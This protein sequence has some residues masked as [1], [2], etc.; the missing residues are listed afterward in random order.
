MIRRV[1]GQQDLPGDGQLRLPPDG[2]IVTLRGV[3]TEQRVFGGSQTWTSDAGIGTAG[4]RSW[5]GDR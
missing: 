3:P 1:G 5:D 4:E 2:H